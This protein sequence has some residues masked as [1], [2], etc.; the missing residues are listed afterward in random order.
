M[1]IDS[2]EEVIP[3]QHDAFKPPPMDFRSVCLTANIRE[4]TRASKRKRD[5][6]ESDIC[7]MDGVDMDDGEVKVVP[8]AK[9]RSYSNTDNF[10][11]ASG[12]TWKTP[13][14]RASNMI[15]KN[16]KQL[17]GTWEEKMQANR[18]EKKKREYIKEVRQVQF[19]KMKAEKERRVE[20]KKEK[21]ANRQKSA[22]VQKVTNSKKLKAMSKKAQKGVRFVKEVQ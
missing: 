13:S 22:I 15:V 10:G 9:R 4:S 12:R 21:E 2:E 18:D 3:P 16:P 7:D 8:S 17:K 11:K 5:V 19:D 14:A 6:E 20:K 1:N